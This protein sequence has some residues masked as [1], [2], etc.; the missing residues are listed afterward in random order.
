MVFEEV[1]ESKMQ[2]GDIVLF[3]KLRLNGKPSEVIKHAGVYCG[4][5]EV[6]HFQSKCL[7]PAGAWDVA[8]AERRPA[9][10]WVGQGDGQIWVLQKT[11]T[12][13]VL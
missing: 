4:D 2:P 3:P 9:A 13:V 11:M 8:V 12:T 7:V 10:P 1:S 5:G 6:I